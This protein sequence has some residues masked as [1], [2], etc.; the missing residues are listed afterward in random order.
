VAWLAARRGWAAAARAGVTAAGT[1]VV[2][3]V[4]AG[5][6]ESLGPLRG[7]SA[8]RSKASVWDHPAAWMSRHVFGSGPPG[9]D[10]ITA[11]TVAVGVLTVVLVAA[12][13]RDLDPAVAAGGAGLVYLLG[14]AYVLP[15]YAGWVLPVLA[16]AWRSRLALVAQLQAGVLLLVYVDRPGV[17]PELLHDVVDPIATRVVPIVEIALLAALLVVSLRRIAPL[18][19]A[20]RVGSRA[21]VA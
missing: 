20:G 12:R 14:A 17:R 21:R 4:L 7:A 1:V 13:V 15:W 2:G 6:V 19:A 3:Y 16:L 18:L 10:L 8:Y 9:A 11:A 5:G